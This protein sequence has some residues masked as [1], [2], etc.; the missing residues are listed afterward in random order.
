MQTE[1]L[2]MDKVPTEEEKRYIRVREFSLRLYG[3]HEAAKRLSLASQLTPERV[4]LTESSD[5]QL[6]LT[7]H[8]LSAEVIEMPGA[9]SDTQLWVTYRGKLIPRDG[10]VVYMDRWVAHLLDPTT[11]MFPQG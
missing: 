7:L 11:P 8:G 6:R 9:L 4:Q 10:E 5:S 2:R 1:R 3:L